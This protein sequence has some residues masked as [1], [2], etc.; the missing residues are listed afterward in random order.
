MDAQGF[1]ETHL[2]F[3][4]IL[5]PFFLHWINDL[6]VFLNSLRKSLTPQG[7][8]MAAMLGGDS[9]RSLRDI[10]IQIELR[11][12]NVKPHI[13][14]FCTP[15]HINRY[16]QHAGFAQWTIE[17]EQF[18]INYTSLRLLFQDMKNLGQSNALCTRFQGLTR[19]LHASEI[20]SLLKQGDETFS[21]ALDTFFM[22]GFNRSSAA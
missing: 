15:E 3:D 22:T 12:K 20:E 13:L 19:S 6:P 8:L 16:L 4:A 21:V 18:S 2:K 10:F 5:C 14:P 17:E 7:I 9:L 1:V 11:K